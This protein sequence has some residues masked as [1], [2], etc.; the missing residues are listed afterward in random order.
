MTTTTQV[1]AVLDYLVAACKASTLL[2]ALQPVPVVVFDGP[3]LTNDTAAQP[4]HLWIGFDPMN[5]GEAAATSA[6]DWP[7]LDH[8]RTDDEDGEIV[9]VA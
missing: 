5:P 3:N 1:P 6:Q 7:V 9:C 4:L 2:G 8:A